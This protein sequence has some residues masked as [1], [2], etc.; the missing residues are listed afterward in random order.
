M[1]IQFMSC[2]YGQKYDFQYSAPNLHKFAYAKHMRTLEMGLS[3]PQTL[4]TW[5]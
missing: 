3:E 2:R 1:F 5:V 4:K